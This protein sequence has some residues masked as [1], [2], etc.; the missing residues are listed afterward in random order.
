MINNPFL[1]S[2]GLIITL[3]SSMLAYGPWKL[4]LFFGISGHSLWNP[5]NAFKRSL[6]M[7]VVGFGSEPSEDGVGMGGFVS[8]DMF[9]P[10]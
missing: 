5:H 6:V 4:L 8:S 2:N 10:W 3:M 7:F 9:S 1:A